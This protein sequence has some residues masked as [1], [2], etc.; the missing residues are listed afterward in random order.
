MKILQK[1]IPGA[2]WL[3]AVVKCLLAMAP[4]EGLLIG[5]YLEA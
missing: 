1:E 4:G 5:G 2:T 3:L